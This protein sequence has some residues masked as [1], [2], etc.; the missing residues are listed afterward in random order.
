[1]HIILD[2]FATMKKQIV[3]LI[4]LT[5]NLTAMAQFSFNLNGFITDK[6]TGESLMGVKVDIKDWHVESFTNRYGFFSISSP[7]Q[8]I[9]LVVNYEG[10]A[11]YRDTLYIEQDKTF[12]IQL[13]QLIVN[14][15]E[16]SNPPRNQNEITDVLG[17][18]IDLSMNFT[19]KMPYMLGETDLIKGLQVLPG[20]KFGNEGFSNLFVRGGA[21]DQNLFLIDGMPIYNSNHAFGLI[22][23]YNPEA[24]N[25][26]QLHKGGFAARYGGRLSSVVDMT[27]NDGTADAIHGSVSVTPLSF[28]V[29]LAGAFKNKVTTYSLSVRR[30]YFDILLKPIFLAGGGSFDLN[31]QDVNAKI[32]HKIGDDDKVFFTLY[33]GRDLFKFSGTDKDSANNTTKQTVQSKWG[34]L[35]GSVRWNHVFNQRLFSSTSIM[36]SQYKFGEKFEEK[37]TQNTG[38]KS[39]QEYNY[40]TGI[41]DILIHSDFEYNHH[42]DHF[43]RF[44]VQTSLRNFNTGKVREKGTGFINVDDFDV[45]LGANNQK[46]GTEIALYAE[47]DIR[48][49]QNLKLNAGMRLVAY[50]YQSKL[51][52]APEPRLS[53]RYLINDNL[54]IKTS[55]CRM[56][57]FMH[58]LTNAGTGAPSIYWAPAT[59][60][61]KPQIA[62]QI[63]GGFVSALSNEYQ[64]TVD[65]YWKSMRNL[66]TVSNQNNI[67]DVE[68]DWQQAVEQGKGKSYGLEILLK[69]KYGKVTGIYGYTLSKSTRQFELMN[70]GVAF[71]YNYD[72]RHQ[73]NALFQFWISDITAL[74]T[75]LVIG[76]GNP[77]TLPLGKYLDIDGREILDY[78]NI[79]NYR[80]PRYTRLDIGFNKNYGELADD[81]THELNFSI[82][83]FFLRKNPSTAYAV[84]EQDPFGNNLYKAYQNSYFVFLPGIHY[85]IR[86]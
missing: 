11:E 79:N 81:V 26:V 85:V 40:G 76:S 15:Y 34:N 57:Q 25:N 77:F 73:F 82:Y 56:N 23:I 38:N 30:S 36:Y 33:Y 13:E 37:I 64:L 50:L 66:V 61:V 1:M 80:A 71:P 16:E 70:N 32:T 21:A 62:D 24:I 4:L 10:Y 63:T 68:K 69:K 59:D 12:Y 35:A 67:N 42:N 48:V 54:S 43:I 6:K 39:S 9:V 17:N 41:S 14:E 65:L 53:V 52:Y 5:I 29:A 22:S 28:K 2:I 45:T 55:Y 19:R 3:F 27:T 84:L 46:R 86:F 31:Y 7:P 74:S 47:D 83:N 8:D 49:N 60:R 75:N 72:R 78:G 51:T 44:G 18:R 20:V 58:L